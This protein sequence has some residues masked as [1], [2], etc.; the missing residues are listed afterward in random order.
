MAPEMMI[1]NNNRNVSHWNLESGY[2]SGYSE[3][4]YPIRASN[5]NGFFDIGL[6]TNVENR[7]V[8]CRGAVQGFR[9]SLTVPGEAVQL[10]PYGLQAHFSEM[11]R[12]WMK[13]KLTTTSDGLRKYKPSR[14]G[15][16]FNDE[17]RLRFFKTYTKNNCDIECLANFTL[18]HCG[19]VQFSMPSNL[20]FSFYL[21]AFFL[22]RV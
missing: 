9:L 22:Y 12:I 13:P 14:R 19:C 11:C 10:P 2:E 20:L 1:V 6:V 3:I 4:G 7:Q 18:S 21:I 8:K 15:C 17:R 5:P 16:Y